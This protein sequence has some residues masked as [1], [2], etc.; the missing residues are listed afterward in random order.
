MSTTSLRHLSGP[1]RL[2]RLPRLLPFRRWAT[3]A[4]ERRL[5]AALDAR[6]LRDIG[7][8]RAEAEREA[9]RPFWDAGGR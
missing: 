8:S 5:L 1:R 9:A 4:R 2:P 3:V 7:R 6:M